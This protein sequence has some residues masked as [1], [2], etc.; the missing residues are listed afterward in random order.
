MI[1]FIGI[2]Y[3]TSNMTVFLKV[4]YRKGVFTVVDEY[5]HSGSESQNYKTPSQY[6]ED[7]KDFIGEDSAFVTA[8]YADPSANF[9]IQE[10]KKSGI[11]GFKSSVNDIIPGIQLMQNLFGMKKILFK[12]G[13][14]IKCLM[15]LQ[16]YKWDKANEQR[17]KDVPLKEN[18]HFCDCLR[19]IVSSSVKNKSVNAYVGYNKRQANRILTNY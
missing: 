19:Y 7:L 3:G 18:D 9:F 2:D 15:Q 1:I 11:K 5:S 13:K 12:M 16:G 8:V 10:C 4:Y 6:V 17:G 14:T